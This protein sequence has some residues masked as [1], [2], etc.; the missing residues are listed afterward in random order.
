MENLFM[1]DKSLMSEIISNLKNLKVDGW[2][3]MTALVGC[4]VLLE[5]AMDAPEPE[6]KTETITTEEV[7]D[8]G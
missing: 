1:I 3:S 5:K 4:V 8:N 6:T 2:E 7:V